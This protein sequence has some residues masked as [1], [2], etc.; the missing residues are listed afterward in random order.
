MSVILGQ[1]D[2]YYYHKSGTS[3]WDIAGPQVLIQCLGGKLT[4]AHGHII[5]Y[6]YDK[7]N[8]TNDNGLICAFDDIYFQYVVDKHKQF[9]LY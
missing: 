8:V 3:R 2:V 1:G 5:P 4:D 7:H 6:I 9:L